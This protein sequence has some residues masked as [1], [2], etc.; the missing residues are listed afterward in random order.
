MWFV[1]SLKISR[2]LRGV[3]EIFK[4]ATDEMTFKIFNPISKS[5]VIKSKTYCSA[6]LCNLVFK[7]F[8]CMEDM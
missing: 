6:S 5:Y 4:S 7:S 1:M 3:Q 2:F 8:K